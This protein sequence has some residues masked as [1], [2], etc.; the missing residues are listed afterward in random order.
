MCGDNITFHLL[1]HSAVCYF[2]ELRIKHKVVCIHAV[3]ELIWEVSVHGG[4]I[5]TVLRKLRLGIS[6]KCTFNSILVE[7]I[8]GPFGRF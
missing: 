2:C 7:Y 5:H 3:L 4:I 8:N 1:E 6:A